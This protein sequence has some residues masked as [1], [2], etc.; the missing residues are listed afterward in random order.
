MMA[1]VRMPVARAAAAGSSSRVSGRISVNTGR[2]PF[3][4][5]AW[6]VAAKVNDGSTTSPES[7]LTRRASIR[8][9]VQQDTAMQWRTPR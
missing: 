4:A 5:T 6:A 1:E 3:Q 2:S 7:S 9:A 8:P